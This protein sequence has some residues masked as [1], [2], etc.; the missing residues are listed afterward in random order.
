MNVKRL[1][2][3]DTQPERYAYTVDP[4]A[5]FVSA[6]KASQRW[7]PTTCGYCS[8][9]CGMFIGVTDGRAVSV[10]GNPGHPVNRGMLCPK[11]LSE[12]YTIAAEGRARSPLLKQNGRFVPVAW[13][14]ALETMAETF[15]DVQSKHG[16]GALGVINTGQLVTEEFY[17]LG[18]L[19]QIG[20]GTPNY[21][22]NTTLCMSTAVAGYKR[23]FGSDGPPGAYEDLECADVILL[24]G[25]N[26]ADNHPIL[27]R[28]IEANPETTLIVVDPRVTK[29][30]MMADLHL[31]IRPRSD[32]ALINGLIRIVIEC[33]LIDREYIGR[34]TSGFEALRH[35]LRE[36]TPERVSEITGL[37]VEQLYRTAALYANARAAFIGWTMGV[38]HSSKG[39]ETVNAIN[40][41]ALIT[42]NIGRAGA[43]PFSITGQCNAM[44][45]REAGGASCLPGYRK[46]ESAADREE[47]AALWNVPVER[48]PTAR[49]LAY[50]DI[51]EA[52]LE[53]RIRALWIIA[54]NPIVSF[55][56]VGRLRQALEALDFL[57]VQDGFHPTPTSELAHL[58]LPA[59]IW[60]E[61]EGTYT[62]AERRVSKVNR[63]VDSPGEARP[64]FNIF[65]DLAA[66]LGV[67][68]ELFPGWSTPRDAF[69]EWKRVSAGRLCDYSGMTYEA[70]EEHG[71]IQWPFPAGAT[72]P[73]QSRRLYSDG[74]FQ[75]DDGRARLIPVSWEPFPEQPSSDFPLVL[76]T[77]RTV[78][79]WHT[80]TK[81]GKVPI[82]EHLSPTAWV[83]LNPRDARAL[84]LTTDDRVDV[85]SRRGRVRN[86]ELRLT[87]T[88]APGQVFVPFHFAEANA[89][90][91]TLDV[92]DPISREPNFKQSAVR[93][94]RT[95]P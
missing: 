12:H 77:G 22:G 49:G 31:P 23:S 38:N 2:G 94:E 57:V 34:Q 88:V 60:G 4:V 62:N 71:G 19:V 40:N 14:H 82:L 51:V 44:G 29:T 75:T 84:R 16:P 66:A 86:V 6:Q 56:N 25:A 15:R 3:L 73:A 36:Y 20:L 18:K 87:Q 32:L 90:Q 27:C 83:E 5:G 37:T 95:E 59:A 33:D 21:D 47:I 13:S 80:R 48:I 65:L 85:V 52:A 39:T 43:A 63:A 50:P 10:R 7:I 28:R 46:F 11:G 69:E 55:P 17:T 93:V 72:D 67:R 54:T 61:K 68:G 9:G 91:I 81:T 35:S 8:V 79:H 26:I 30:A 89:N 41:L 78:E 1:L 24:I 64:D 76:N 92:F 45:T 58:V 42:G 70:I 53:R 74:H